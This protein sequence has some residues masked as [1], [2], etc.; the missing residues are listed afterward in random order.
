MNVDSLMTTQPESR[1]ETTQHSSLGEASSSVQ[2]AAAPPLHGLTPEALQALREEGAQVLVCSGSCRMLFHGSKALEGNSAMILPADTACSESA[3]IGVVVLGTAAAPPVE[4]DHTD[5]FADVDPDYH[6]LI[7]QQGRRTMRFWRPIEDKVQTIKAVI[8]RCLRT[9]GIFAQA[10][11]RPRKV[12][13]KRKQQLLEKKGG[14]CKKSDVKLPSTT[15]NSSLIVIKKASGNM[16][17]R[18]SNRRPNPTPSIEQL[19]KLAGEN[20]ECCALV[21]VF[22]EWKLSAP[23]LSALPLVPSLS[24]QLPCFYMANPGTSQGNNIFGNMMTQESF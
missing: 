1:Q 21:V 6:M 2:V 12:N 20:D 9:N 5:I 19:M 7:V 13:R 22:D 14:S 23:A 10:F 8:G 24:S 17:S 16:K 3:P 15:N 18:P 11:C 4:C